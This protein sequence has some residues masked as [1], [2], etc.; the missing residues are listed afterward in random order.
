MSI[1][2]KLQGVLTILI[3]PMQIPLVELATVTTWK[4]HGTDF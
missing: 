4:P 1:A 3:D 2:S